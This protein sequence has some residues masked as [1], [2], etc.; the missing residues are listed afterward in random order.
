M[1]HGIQRASTHEFQAQ[2][3]EFLIHRPFS[4]KMAANYNFFVS[5]KI[6]PTNLVFK[7]ISTPKRV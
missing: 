5:I 6:S 1:S 4:Y 7:R 3:C 2:E